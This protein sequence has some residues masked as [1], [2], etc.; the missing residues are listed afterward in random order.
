MK[1]SIVLLSLALV[2]CLC[3]SAL[4]SATGFT[5]TAEEYIA[6]YTDFNSLALQKE[7]A[8]SEPAD[9]ADGLTG[10][11]G[12][13]EDMAKVEV[14]TIQGDTACVGIG[15]LLEV[16][17]TDADLTAKSTAFGMTVAAI[18]YACRYLE[19]GNDIVALADELQPIQD[20]CTGLV[21]TVFGTDAVTAAMTEPFTAEAEIAG[22]NAK[23]TLEVDIETMTM[24]AT[25]VFLP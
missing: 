25:F 15:T 5:F 21:Q 10:W 19:L 13:A 11:A 4:A 2:L 20:A 6:A 12:T 16:G 18:P 24:K 9:T 23:M 1:K 14:Y 7:V 22:H 17:M 3:G 8:W